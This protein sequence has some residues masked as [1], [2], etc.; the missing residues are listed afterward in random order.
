MVYDPDEPVE[1]APVP[2]EDPLDGVGT[3]TEDR[4]EPPPT[5]HP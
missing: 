2:D 4:N 3:S 1:D 5:E